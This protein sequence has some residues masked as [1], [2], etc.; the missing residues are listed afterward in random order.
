LNENVVAFE[1]CLAAPASESTGAATNNFSL[2]NIHDAIAE[3]SE[4]LFCMVSA[5]QAAFSVKYK[6]DKSPITNAT[7]QVE[8]IRKQAKQYRL[9]PFSGK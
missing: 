9:K 3:S 6:V 2:P 5:T 4:Y 8:R 7:Q 1:Q